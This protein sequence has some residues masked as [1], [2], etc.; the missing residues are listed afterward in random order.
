MLDD[1]Y[2]ER[3]AT[4]GDAASGAI[5][6]LRL[7][8]VGMIVVPLLLGAAGAYLSHRATYN[9]AVSG[10]ADAVA[11]AEENTNKVLETHMLVAARIEDLL[12]GLSD[13]YIR[14]NERGLHERIAEQIKDV[15][16][17]AAAWVIDADG[18]ELVSARVYPVDRTLINSSRKDFQVLKDPSVRAYIW[19]VRARSLQGGEY[20]PYFTVSRRLTG[21]D[22]S[23]RGII[24]V[25]VSG[26][27]VASFYDSLLGDTSYTASVLRDDGTILAHYPMTGETVA[28]QSDGV[29]DQAMAAK[30]PS[31]IVATG[32]PLGMKGSIVAY[33]RLADYPI[34]VTIARTRASILREWL[35]SILGYTAIGLAAAIGLMALTLLALRRTRREQQALAQARDAI[36]ERAAIEA[37]LYQAQKMEAVGLLTAGIAHDFNNLLTVVAGHIELLESEPDCPAPRREKLIGLALSGCE[38][39]AALTKRLLSFARRE[40]AD[41]QPTDANEVIR[42]LSELPWRSMSDQIATEFRLQ[43]DLWS[44]FVDGQQLENAL[45]NIALNARDAMAGRGTLTIETVNTTFDQAYAEAHAGVTTGDYVEIRISDTGCGM[46]PEVRKRAFDPF[47]S[48][49]E[50]GKGTG[51]G[52]SQVY[53]FVT[54]FGGYCAIDSASGQGTTIKFYLPRYVGEGEVAEASPAAARDSGIAPRL[55]ATGR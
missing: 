27:Y 14:A 46:P 22:G 35:Y 23:F 21:L 38:R 9:N 53:G 45:L 26:N 48:T 4:A 25:A 10:L 20:Q 42:G 2:Q 12:G 55:W 1:K 3:R 43:P 8:F 34:Y 17:V 30:A 39:A 5:R 31:G 49:K 32:S 36:A 13:D 40:P 52:L 44:V 33:R 15:P 11:V 47:F 6:A 41:P 51:L 37:Q 28:P 24:V 50:A 19:A 29:L 7:L 54:R 16:E 18:H